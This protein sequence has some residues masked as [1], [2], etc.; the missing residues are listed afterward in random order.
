MSEKVLITGA[1]GFLGYH[2]INAAVENG[3]DVYAAIRKSSNIQHLEGLPIHY[4]APDYKDI[5]ALEKL[6]EEKQFDYVIHAAGIT[7][8]NDEAEYDL[9]NNIYTQNLAMA[10]AKNKKVKRF[11]FV[12]SLAAL[13]PLKNTGQ[14]ITEDTIP[15]PVTAYG[16]SK[17]NA[18]NNL[19]KAGIAFTI[20]RP[21][22]IYGPREK[23]IFIVTKT[24]NSGV[25]AYIGRV[26]QRLSFVYGADMGV[27]AVK[28]L[29][30]TGCGSA[31]Y[32]ITDGNSYS[33]YAYADIVKKILGKKAVRFH[34]PLPVIKVI[35][36]AAEKINKAMNRVAP[37]SIEKLN[38]LM[39]ESW[40]CDISKAKKDLGFE[41]KFDLEKGL[42][43]TI[44]WYKENKWL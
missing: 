35:F 5:A 27:V 31:S 18:E 6:F 38:E 15:N 30:Q 11:V 10:A 9:V 7:K 36:F 3:Y 14:N 2:I 40:V 16:K 1:S 17:L 33:R 22:A 19:K 26:N 34:L 8:T 43:A 44:N 13:G 29:K 4:V 20:L 39:A 25:D 42:T 32:N 41:P 37:V 28:A 21:T 23:D 12:S 24:L